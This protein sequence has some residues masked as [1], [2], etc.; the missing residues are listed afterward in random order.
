VRS[1]FVGDGVRDTCC[2]L[3]SMRRG[4]VT[5][6]VPFK[7]VRR[8]L[9][10]QVKNAG[11][12]IVEVPVNH[13]PRQFGVSKYVFGNCAVR[14]TLDMFGVRCC[15]RA[16]SFVLEESP[17]VSLSYPPG[18]PPAARSDQGARSQKEVLKNF[19]GRFAAWQGGA[20]KSAQDQ[21][22]GQN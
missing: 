22:P 18:N 4:C 6:L 21:A 16:G 12:R 19:Q 3:K 1:R 7:R 11:F 20:Q 10:D 14:A 5:P 8:F 9:T 2:T 13:R 17:E 15:S